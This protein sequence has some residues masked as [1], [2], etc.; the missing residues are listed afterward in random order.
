MTYTKQTLLLLFPIEKKKTTKNMEEL[1]RINQNVQLKKKKNFEL[2]T[3][4][5]HYK[6]M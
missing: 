2:E 5:L 3:G 1:F 6:A 4:L